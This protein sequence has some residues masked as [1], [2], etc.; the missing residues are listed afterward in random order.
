MTQIV[1]PFKMPHEAVGIDLGD[2]AIEFRPDKMI[3]VNKTLGDHYTIQMD[4]PSGVLD[5]HRTWKD[6]SGDERHKTIFAMRRSDIPKLIGE[7]SPV[8][9]GLLSFR[10]LRLGWLARNGIAI[11]R[12]LELA[13]T[14]EIAKV[15]R[16]ARRKRLVLDE[17]KLRAQLQIPEYLEEIWDF[18]DGPFSLVQ[19][20]RRIGI[21]IKPTDQFGEPWLCWMK[22]RGL[23][24]RSNVAWDRI[25]KAAMQYAIPPTDY[26]LY[27]FLSR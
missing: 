19:R 15:T 2:F 24:G 11:A 10:R 9:T 17:A 12:G 20:G 7:L 6:E 3:F 5:V 13:T 23:I 4:T 1:A 26:G 18:P 14:D 27:G 8:T 16:R 22:F 21:G 25:S